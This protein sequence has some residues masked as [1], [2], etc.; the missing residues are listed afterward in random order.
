MFAPARRISIA[1]TAVGIMVVLTS[2]TGG[3]ATQEKAGSFDPKLTLKWPEKPIESSQVIDT[4]HGPQKHY[5]A[6]LLNRQDRTLY[7]AAVLEFPEKALKG[8]S[9]KD[10]VAAYV[11]GSKSQETSRKEVEHGKR[12]CPGLEITTKN[13]K[14]LSRKLVVM[15]GSRIYE[16]SVTSP[17]E[18][19][20]QAPSV[21][22]FLESLA[23]GD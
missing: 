23:V 21:K 18:A 9:P 13:E 7:A 2:C 10:L 3:P 6:M 1:I 17:T 22:A 5:N 19:S 4:L 15:A 20:L 16:V 12:K 11:F 14:G 8:S